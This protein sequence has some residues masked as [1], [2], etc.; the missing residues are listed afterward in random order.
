[1][2]ID[3][4]QLIRDESAAFRALHERVLA[5]VRS[6]DWDRHSRD[7]WSQACHEFHTYVSRLDPYL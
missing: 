3:F 4:T 7:E 6:R 5:T 2:K 1:M